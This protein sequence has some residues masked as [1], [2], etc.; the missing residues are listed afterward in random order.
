ML[1]E[2]GKKRGAVPPL[3]ESLPPST[4][5]TTPHFGQEVDERFLLVFPDDFVFLAVG[6]SLSGYEMKV[7][8]THSDS[9]VAACITC[10]GFF[11]SLLTSS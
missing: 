7:N 4:V 8:T 5:N 2:H 3:A 9:T 6:M 11:L 10:L 1:H